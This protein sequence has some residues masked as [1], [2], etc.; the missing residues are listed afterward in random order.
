M[1]GA[2]NVELGKQ[3]CVCL[4]LDKQYE[5][6]PVNY[7]RVVMSMLGIYFDCK[8]LGHIFCIKNLVRI[9]FYQ[10]LTGN[11]DYF[12]T[13][14]LKNYLQNYY[15]IKGALMWRTNLNTKLHTYILASIILFNKNSVRTLF[16]IEVYSEVRW[17]MP[18]QT[19]CAK[20]KLNVNFPSPSMGNSRMYW[21]VTGCCKHPSD[22]GVSRSLPFNALID[23][24]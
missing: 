20:E 11:S 4:S 8:L 13:C 16:R 7:T 18:G 5:S 15:P 1:F 3:S 23:L 6:A 22:S 14:Q 24:L 9:G 21:V 2:G 12:K 17:K 10:K 19:G